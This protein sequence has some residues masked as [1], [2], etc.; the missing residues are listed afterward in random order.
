MASAVMTT[1]TLTS[2]AHAG[3][4]LEYNVMIYSGTGQN[5]CLDA[6]GSHGLYAGD[7]VK[8]WPCSSGDSYEAWDLH[9]DLT[10]SPHS[11]SDLCLDASDPTGTLAVGAAVQ[12]WYCNGGSNQQWGGALGNAVNWYN[13]AVSN[14]TFLYL[15]ANAS[16]PVQA[17][18]PVEVWTLNHGSNQGWAWAPRS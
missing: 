2:Q 10:I 6:D 18:T 12:I 11:N 1:M 13:G 5:L 15:D 17:G 9:D 16:S 3:Y 14:G 7:P 8:L 4:P